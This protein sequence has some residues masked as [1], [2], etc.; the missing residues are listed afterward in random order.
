MDCTL[1]LPD[2]QLCAQE[3][4]SPMIFKIQRPLS[5]EMP[6]KD[7]DAL[8][9]NKDRS[10]EFGIPMRTMVQFWVG[11]GYPEKVYVEAELDA[12]E[13]FVIEAFVEEQSW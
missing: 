7:Y 10:I 4:L 1:A 8:V 5:P 2:Q 12:D 9:Y 3:R 6:A 11:A 13:G